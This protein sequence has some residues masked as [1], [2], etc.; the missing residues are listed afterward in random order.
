M[1]ETEEVQ[2]QS[3][4]WEDP[5][6]EEMQTT[7]LF[8]IVCYSDMLLLTQTVSVC[9][10]MNSACQVSLSFSTTLSL[11]KLMSI[12]SVMPS[13]YLILYHHLLLNHWC[14]PASGTFLMS[15]L[16]TSVGQSI[17]A[18]ASVSVLLMH[19]QGWSS[20]GLTGLISLQSKGLLRA[21][22]NTTVQ[23]HQNSFVLSLLYSQTLTPKHNYWRNHSWTMQTFV[24]KAM[25]LIFNTLSS[26]IIAIHSRSKK[27]SL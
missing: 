27:K 3:L 12:E 15:Q 23:K 7:P 4:G 25:S 13:N 6:E 8:K 21:F 9:N 16:F 17:G 5:L 10:P 14:F 26:F 20:L 24:G 22:C 2:V 18:S 11:F 19:I 1:Q